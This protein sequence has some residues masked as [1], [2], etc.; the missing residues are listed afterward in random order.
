M[1]PGSLS[2]VGGRKKIRDIDVNIGI[3]TDDWE[4]Y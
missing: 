3:Q 4:D 1:L 2:N